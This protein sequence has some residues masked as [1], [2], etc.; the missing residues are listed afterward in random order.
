MAFLS[1]HP[2]ARFKH[3][4]P[5]RGGWFP[6]WSVLVKSPLGPIRLLN[7]HLRPPLKANG[8]VSGVPSAYLSTRSIR[9][10][11]LANYLSAL[12]DADRTPVIVMGDFNE[13]DSGSA[14]QL[15]RRRGFANALAKFDTSTPTWR[16][17]TSLYTF[18]SRLDH[19]LHTKTL[20]CDAAQVLG[21]GGSDHRPVEAVFALNKKQ[22]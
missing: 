20:R 11:Q 7:V 2:L 17:P 6:G 13:S 15:A 1:K 5:P 22:R 12:P 21:D 16:W 8:G 14:L 4:R 10:K 3:L 18:T 19:I 9:R